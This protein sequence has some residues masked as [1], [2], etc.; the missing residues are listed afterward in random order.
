M[1]E[2]RQDRTTGRWVIVAPQRGLRPG[3]RSPGARL[4]AASRAPQPHFDPGCPF[5][6]GN[7]A[8][9]PGIIAETK[10][11]SPPHWA[12]R[13][14]PNKFPALAPEPKPGVEYV[15][16]HRLCGGYGFHEVI[17]ESPRHDTDLALMTDVEIEAAV[18]MY[19][20]RSR[21]LMQRP[22]IEAVVLFRNHGPQGGASVTHPH[23]QAIALGFAPPVPRL[24]ADWGRRYHGEHGQQCP[25]C[26]EIAIEL[27]LGARIV[28]DTQNLLVMVPFAAEYPC[29]T[30]IVPKQHQASFLNIDDTQ[31]AEFARVLWGALARL[32][33][34][35][36]DPPYHFVIDSADRTHLHA[37]YVH[38]RLRI[39][40]DLTT[41]GGFELGAG[42]AINPSRPE[43]DAAMLR[44]AGEG[45]ESGSTN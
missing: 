18:R 4:S 29:E 27:G 7:E 39:A 45:N 23:A 43:N 37:P 30:W 19:R 42:M 15:E 28:E 40:P 21:H 26:D 8:A 3:A 31:I 36:G 25:T 16:Q 44:G 22:G 20:D 10:D 1:N 5:C 11:R 24:L 9:L 14:V 12:V 13:V 2:L 6:P 33:R 32:R 41:H 38:W 17:I 34:V 35:Q